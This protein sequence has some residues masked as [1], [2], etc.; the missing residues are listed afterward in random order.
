MRRAVDLRA[1]LADES[2]S[3][4]RF[5]A[6]LADALMILGNVHR[7]AKRFDEA[8]AAQERAR[9]VLESVVRDHPDSATY[10]TTLASVLNHIGLTLSDADRP[11]EAITRY[12]RALNL[13]API[14][15][16]EPSN[17]EARSLAAGTRNNRG[18]ALAK[19]GRHEEA[20]EDYRKAIEDERICYDA[21]PESYQY[22]NW[23]NLHIYN[24]GKSLRALGRLDEAYATYRDRMKLWAEAPPEHRSPEEHYDAA[25]SLAL[26]APAVGRG[27][28]DDELTEAE[29]ARRRRFT[30]EAFAELQTAVVGGFDRA[31]LFA[32]D[33][34]F[35][36]IRS[37]PRFDP[38]LLRV[39]DRV[40]P[41]DPFAGGR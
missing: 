29:R 9:A 34:D 15:D 23:L 7:N 25:C 14:L 40:F 11:A 10:R 22:R 32:R 12:A 27:K 30:D 8:L 26:L 13:L 3:T 18:L 16:G 35:D 6:N 5:Q 39:M 37:D 41:A 17:V 38:L 28:P 4:A 33:P 1:A 2:P 19:L 21:S 24:M 36:A 20:L 31:A